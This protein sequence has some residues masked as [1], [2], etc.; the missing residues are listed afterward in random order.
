M[1]KRAHVSWLSALVIAV[2]TLIAGGLVPTAASAEGDVSP[3]SAP[4]SFTATYEMHPGP[5]HWAQLRW[6]APESNGG[7]AV[8]GYHLTMN[9]V[10][11]EDPGGPGATIK[12]LQDGGSYEFA[13]TAYNAAGSGPP[14]TATVNV[15]AALPGAPVS[16]SVTLRSA[17]LEADL[18]WDPPA[19]DGGRAIQGYRVSLNGSDLPDLPSSPTS[20]TLSGLQRGQSYEVTVR[21]FNEVGTG[22]TASRPPF[23]V[24]VVSPTIPQSF[25][26]TLRANGQQADLSWTAPASDGGR[27]IQAYYVVANG[28]GLSF[29]T[30]V[31][32]DAR[33][34]T[35]SGLRRGNTYEFSMNANNLVPGMVDGGYSPI[36]SKTLTVP[37]VPPD[38]PTIGRAVSGAKGGRSTAEAHWTPPRNDGG[39]EVDGY[40]VFAY[41]LDSTGKVVQTIQC[42]FFHNEEN[43]HTAQ[44]LK[45]D[46]GKYKFAVRAHNAKGWSV[47]SAKSNTVTA[48]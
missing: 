14:A 30:S 28:P 18:S 27:A 35:V 46:K 22:P 1:S 17:D 16:F 33:S 24:P 48:R 25:T 5:E 20:T 9:G 32:A 10:S 43:Q 37:V 19:S 47:L 38:A 26:V 7:S 12:G 29:G 21:A 11:L 45:L 39:V 34:I 23:R 15:P 31:P 44:V 2:V 13:V 42:R 6:S 40:Q 41:R 3:P 36:A 4:Q 8:Q